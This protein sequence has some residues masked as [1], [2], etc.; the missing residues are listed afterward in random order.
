MQCS[1]CATQS[2]FRMSEQVAVGFTSLHFV[3]LTRTIRL[4]LANAPVLQAVASHSSCMPVSS[5]AS[6]RR[7]SAEQILHYQAQ[8]AP[9]T[10]LFTHV[11]IALMTHIMMVCCSKPAREDA[12]GE[13]T[14]RV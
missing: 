5:Y 12:L 9:A 8:R 4:T 2:A 11:E 7:K 1:S 6:A 14:H 10:K 13:F 3:M